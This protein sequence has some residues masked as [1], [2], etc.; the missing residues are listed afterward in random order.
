M[1][2]VNCDTYDTIVL[3]RTRSH[4]SLCRDKRVSM[5]NCTD[6]EREDGDRVDGLLL[7]LDMVLDKQ[8]RYE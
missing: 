3:P 1:I 5:L 2:G 7:T 6:T 8:V 4:T